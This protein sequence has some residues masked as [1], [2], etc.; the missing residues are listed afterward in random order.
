[1]TYASVT[2]E[3]T[4]AKQTAAHIIGLVRS[5]TDRMLIAADKSFYHVARMVVG[6]L[7]VHAILNFLA[8]CGNT[9]D[10]E[11]RVTGVWCGAHVGDNVYTV[12]FL[13]RNDKGIENTQFDVFGNLGRHRKAATAMALSIV[14]KSPSIKH[15]VNKNN[16]FGIS[17]IGFGS[18]VP[19]VILHPKSSALVDRILRNHVFHRDRIKSDFECRIY[20]HHAQAMKAFS[21]TL[22]A[23]ALDFVANLINDKMITD[24]EFTSLIK[25][26]KGPIVDMPGVWSG[27]DTTFTEGAPLR[28][29]MLAKP[30][31]VEAL[32]A[33]W[34]I[35]RHD[36]T[37]DYVE[38]IRKGL[39]SLTGRKCHRAVAAGLNDTHD[40]IQR[41]VDEMHIAGAR[42]EELRNYSGP[43]ML[44]TIVAYVLSRLPQD[45]TPRSEAEW[46]SLARIADPLHV[47]L[48]T[49]A[50]DIDT[51][52]F[53]NAKGRWA[54]TTDR[55]A[56]RLNV[57]PHEVP[58]LLP[59]VV[60]GVT[61]MVAAFA[62]QVAM[63][64]L[65][66]SRSLRRDAQAKIG[67]HHKIQLNNDLGYVA[68]ALARRLLLGGRSL[69]SILELSVRWHGNQAVIDG[70]IET[71]TPRIT[72][73]KTLIDPSFW[74]AGLPDW[75]VNGILIKVLTTQREL[76]DEG[77]HGKNA[78]GS[79]GLAHCVGGYA[80]QCKMSRTRIISFRKRTDDGGESRLST[81]QI[82]FEGLAYKAVVVQHYGPYNTT[83]PKSSGAALDKY[84][85]AISDGRLQVDMAAIEPPEMDITGTITEAA[86][87][88]WDIPGNVEKAMSV[89]SRFMPRGMR[90]MTAADLAKLALSTVELREKDLVS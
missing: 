41:T 77:R 11:G 89:W 75:D 21:A 52:S 64:A 88:E 80:W 27:L 74:P 10:D 16:G 58:V 60:A 81:A 63:P 4:I 23:E 19:P 67:E 56:K 2:F 71:I 25:L 13:Y 83:P 76:E 86:G 68:K 9:T 24:G 33:A 29:A 85:A 37:E 12:D 84:M 15:H 45:W 53:I 17:W 82:K 30:E 31:H 70:A 8:P 18:G 20:A 61:D 90:M 47:A 34:S 79:D 36:F 66:V 22:D 49:L 87:Y 40:A 43:Y 57:D 26:R 39:S 1:M 42:P 62:R 38:T 50:T 72:T 65:A 51:S 14:Q 59:S 3:R 54:E 32:V 28:R 5:A 78:D 46:V 35:S 55:L 6:W 73:G 7:P 69:G 48:R 44:T